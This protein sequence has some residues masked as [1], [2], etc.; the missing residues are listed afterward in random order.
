MELGIGSIIFAFVAGVLSILSPCVIPILP[1]VIGSA[2]NE[3]R[4]GPLMLALGLT[5]SFAVLGTL[6]ASFGGALGIDSER[7]RS[8]AAI[9]M[10]LIGLVLVSPTLQE[11]FA[12]ATAQ[13]SSSGNSL[14]S[15][16]NI[17]GAWGQFALG[18]LLGIIWAPCV[19]PTLGAAVTLASQGKDLAMVGLV[20]TTFGLGAGIPLA[21]LGLVSRQGFLKARGTIVTFAKF[22]KNLMGSFLILMGALIL[23]GWDKAIEAVLVGASPDW[24]TNLTTRF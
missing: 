13:I 16:V 12:I 6:L 11:K 10:L 22:G 1:I 24:L 17:K 7:F 21:V 5:I 8:V 4:Y 9:L 19:G 2:L 18:L 20:M 14:L 15:H 23:L 3:H